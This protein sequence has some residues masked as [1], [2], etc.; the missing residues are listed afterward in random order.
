[1]TPIKLLLAGTAEMLD[2]LIVIVGVKERSD[3]TGENV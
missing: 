1:M 3:T 2:P